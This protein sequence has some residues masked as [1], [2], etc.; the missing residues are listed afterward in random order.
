MADCLNEIAGRMGRREIVMI[1]SDFFTDLDELE[2]VL[3]R[4]RYNRHEVVLFQVMHHDELAFEFDGMVKFVGLEVPDELLAQTDDL[5]RGYLAGREAIQ[6]PLRGNRPAQRLRAGA[7]RY[8]A[9]HERAV[10]RLSQ[11]AEHAGAE[12]IGGSDSSRRRYGCLFSPC[13][14]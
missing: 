5:R 8:A 12:A 9:A 10:H 4:L 3:Q 14:L 11:Q 1:F 6:R 13:R 2:P 7:G